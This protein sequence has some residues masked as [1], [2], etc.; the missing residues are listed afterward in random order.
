[1]L[2]L[3]VRS[4]RS[5]YDCPRNHAR[6]LTENTLAGGSMRKLLIA[7][8]LVAAGAVSALA[9]EEKN[10]LAGTI[11]RTIISDQTPPNT[12]FFNNTVHFGHGTSFEVNYARHLRSYSWWGS[13]WVEVPAIF[14]PDE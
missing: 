9:Q 10:E 2:Q 7:A 11:G 3:I 14:N 12:S 13:L 1:M 4:P 5:N 6:L 8:L